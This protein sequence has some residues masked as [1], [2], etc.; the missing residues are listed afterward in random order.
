M[1]DDDMQSL[2]DWT[3]P[4]AVPRSYIQKHFVD[5]LGLKLSYSE[6]L[7]TFFLFEKIFSYFY[8]SSKM[9]KTEFISILTRLIK[10]DSARSNTKLWLSVLAS[11]SAGVSVPF[12][13]RYISVNAMK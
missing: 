13:I 7:Q 4:Y 5:K 2:S 6:M 9:S 10:Q 12:L 11:F 3:P 8:S 1:E